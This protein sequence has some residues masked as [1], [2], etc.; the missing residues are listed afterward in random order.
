VRHL[1][2]PLYAITTCCALC[3]AYSA[4][5][6]RFAFEKLRHSAKSTYS[7]GGKDGRRTV[8]TGGEADAGFNCAL[9][10]RAL[11]A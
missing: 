9:M 2:F 1:F 8:S 11:C 6:S 7:L 10:I 3:C 5:L 4:K